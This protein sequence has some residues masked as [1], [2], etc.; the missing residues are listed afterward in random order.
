MH[1]HDV[2]AYNQLPV[3]SADIHITVIT[4]P[5]GPFEFQRLPFS[6]HN[7]SQT[8]RRFTDHIL[9]DLDFVSAYTDDVLVAS[10]SMEVHLSHQKIIYERFE[11]YGIIIN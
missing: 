5:F 7:A 11:K 4:N 3:E 1:I 9:R 2:I 8:F 6:L 10:Y